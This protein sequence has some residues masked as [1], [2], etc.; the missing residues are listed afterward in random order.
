MYRGL[1]LLALVCA[2]ACASAQDDISQPQPVSYRPIE[3]AA[4]IRPLVLSAPPRET[5]D[6]AHR[7]YDP[8]ASFLSEVIG[9]KVVF[10]Y[11]STWGAYQAGVTR[12]R[13]D[14]VFDGPHFNGWRV[15]RFHHH[16]LVRASG[17]LTMAVIVKK[18]AQWTKLGALI[19]RP[20]CAPSPPYLGTLIVEAEFPNPSRTPYIEDEGGWAQEYTALIGGRC[21]AAIVPEKV[22]PKVD[23]TRATRVIYTSRAVPN[24]ALSASARVSQSDQEK[25]REALLSPAGIEATAAVRAAYGLGG[26]FVPADDS[27]Y[28]QFGSLLKD[29]FGWD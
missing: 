17:N 28:L 8:I 16:V 2:S 5:A 23:P 3:V 7:L 1:M 6:Q 11:S 20:I 13:Y 19:G 22:I 9:R 27:D 4:G 12:D 24:Q 18:D 21:Q 26:A 29:Q 15:E 25:I 10:D 14:L